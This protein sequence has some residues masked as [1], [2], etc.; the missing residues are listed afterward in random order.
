MA[1]TEN[2]TNYVQQFVETQSSGAVTAPVNGSWIVAFC[3]HL[4]VT[5]PVNVSWLQALCNYY[6]ITAPLHGSWTI[7]LAFHFNQQVPINESWWGAL[8]SAEGGGVPVDL[9]WNQVLT[10]WNDETTLWKDAAAPAAPEN[11]GGTFSTKLPLITGTGTDGLEVRVE[12]DGYLYTN[13][14]VSGGIWSL[15]TTE[16]LA[17]SA[18]PGTSYQVTSRQFDSSTGL[19]SVA[20]FTDIFII[21][22]ST[23]VTFDLFD[24][25]G[26]GWNNGWMKLQ[27]DIGGVFTDVD[28][29]NYQTYGAWNNAAYTGTFQPYYNNG[30]FATGSTGMIFEQY[31]PLSAPAN[32]PGRSWTQLID[33]Y[34]FDLD[35]ADYRLVSV[36]PGSYTTERSVTV[37]ETIG[38]ATIATVP[39][40]ANWGAT[41]TLATFTIT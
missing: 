17:G 1:I 26:D 38:G 31:D 39:T 4:G 36:A 37:K 18:S 27:Q 33:T 30:S 16:I 14:A 21:S 13:I 22:T 24:S 10:L 23:S 41:G 5:E 8:A 20:D 3:L 11:D 32:S 12:V 7:A 28:L 15:Q 40:S 34:I 6:G 35:P 2:T 19:E 9:I 25:Y 29:P